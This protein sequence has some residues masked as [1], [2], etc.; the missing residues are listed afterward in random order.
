MPDPRPRSRERRAALAGAA[1]VA[2]ASLLSCA[3]APPALPVVTIALPPAAA[4][5]DPP[6][7]E[8]RLLAL[9]TADNPRIER[10]A[11]SL[12]SVGDPPRALPAIERARRAFAPAFD[13]R[14]RAATSAT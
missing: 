1:I 9:F 14:Q 10:V 12:A 7:P 6:T 5:V 4:G 2:S 3:G 11:M 8:E 13:A